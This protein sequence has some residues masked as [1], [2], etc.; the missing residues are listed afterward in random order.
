MISA[1]RGREHRD[2]PPDATANIASS[3]NSAEHRVS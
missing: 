1:A 2:E 3:L